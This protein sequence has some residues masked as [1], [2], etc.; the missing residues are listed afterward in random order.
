MTL[1]DYCRKEIELEPSGK[2]G[3]I[4]TGGLYVVKPTPVAIPFVCLRCSGK[5]CSTHRLPENHKCNALEL[6]SVYWGKDKHP[7]TYQ[8]PSRP[9]TGPYPEYPPHGIA[10]SKKI[11]RYYSWK[12]P[13]KK[14][15]YFFLNN[16]I[17]IIILLLFYILYVI[18]F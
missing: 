3:T 2:V 18:S 7:G 10:K 8:T 11:I 12:Y 1:C 5:F 13:L 16:S 15:F 17:I 4:I 14:I 6:E 9:T